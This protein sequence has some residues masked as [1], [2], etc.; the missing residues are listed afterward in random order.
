[1]RM[2]S[3]SAG[4]TRV[5]ISTYG[6]STRACS[7]RRRAT[8]GDVL[9]DDILASLTR[10]P[11]CA[12]FASSICRPVLPAG[13]CRAA[14]GVRLH[15]ERAT[16]ATVQRRLR[17]VEDQS[18]AGAAPSPRRRPRDRSTRTGRRAASSTNSLSRAAAVLGVKPSFTREE[19]FET[20]A[21]ACGKDQSD[22]PPVQPVRKNS[23]PVDAPTPPVPSRR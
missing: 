14:H 4:H 3:K 8:S 20:T 9:F 17:E 1:M 18:V 15:M 21:L 2:L 16:C 22:H 6:T 5:L 13:S 12:R 23:T 19:V 7:F 10:S 11:T